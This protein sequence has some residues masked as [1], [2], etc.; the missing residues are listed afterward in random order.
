MYSIA[1]T[2]KSRH[3]TLRL[4]CQMSIWLNCASGY[5]PGNNALLHHLIIINQGRSTASLIYKESM[6]VCAENISIHTAQL[7]TTLKYSKCFYFLQAFDGVWIKFR[8]GGENT[9]GFVAVGREKNLGPCLRRRGASHSVRHGNRWG[10]A[11]VW[12]GGN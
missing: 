12:A 3:L 4:S 11:D 10:E 8:M 9:V 1:P 5:M 6:R 7:F 2:L